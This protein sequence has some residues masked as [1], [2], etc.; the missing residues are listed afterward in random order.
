MKNYRAVLLASTLL[1]LPAVASADEYTDLLDI[2]KAKGSLS[3][4]EYNSLMAKHSHGAR[5]M[6][7]RRGQTTQLYAAPEEE[8]SSASARQAAIDAAA[9]AAAAQAAMRQSQTMMT[10]ME[11]DPGIVHAEPYKLGSGVTIRV[12]AVDLNFSAIVN[13]FYTYSSAD[14]ATPGTAVGGGLADAS[15]FDSSAIRNGL[16]PGAFIASASTTQAGID[17]SAVFGMYPGLNSAS[18]GLLNANNG[19]TSTA[20]GTSGVDFRKTYMTFGTKELGTIK[21]GRDIGIFGSDAILNDAT[22]LSVGSSGNNAD[23]ANTS[24]GRIGVGYIYTDF[25]PQITYISP[26]FAGF[27]G[28][29][30]MFQPLNE[31]AFAGANLSGTATAHNVPLFEGKVTYDAKFSGV[32]AHVWAGV[33]TQP[34]QNIQ[35]V[36][37]LDPNPGGSKDTVAG[38]AGAKLTIGPFAATGYYYRG[39][40]VG[41]TGKFFDG[42]APNGELRDSEGFYAQGAYNITPKL[43]LVGSYGES[44]LYEAPGE[45]TP[46][47][48]R[49]NSSEIGA[50]YFTLTDWV[51]LVAEYAHEEATSHGPNQAH[52]NAFTAGAILFY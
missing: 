20:L 18:V 10:Q 32:A 11:N 27:Q 14:R 50:G 38:E 28:T 30:G 12:G 46:N 15:G 37:N 22:L 43:K 47:L 52:S 34:Q 21:I 4:S 31:F 45:F 9:S 29:V 40:G 23:P 36:G 35:G 3:S 16:L 7:G 48:V 49:R 5:A 51:T 39:K 17:V 13:G 24:L 41:T 25:M 1:L 42:I 19:G 2:L 44:S 33:M 6:K 8:Q 26:I